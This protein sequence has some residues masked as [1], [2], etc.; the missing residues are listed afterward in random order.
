M[1]GPEESLRY[2]G[3]EL[4]RLRDTDEETL[5]RVVNE[6][7]AHLRPWM[8][9]VTPAG[10][11]PRAAIA[12]FLAHTRAAWDAGDSYSYAITVNG[13]IIG[14]CG[15][16]QRIGP[17]GLEVGYW[18]HPAYTGHGYATAAAAALVDQAFALSG[19]ERVQ[20]WHDIANTA[21]AAVPRRLGFTQIARRTPPRDP[22]TPGEV[23][24]DVV[25]ELLR[26]T[27]DVPAPSDRRRGG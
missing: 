20:I 3:V 10:E 1:S 19:I 21:S 22:M 7:L 25:W 4:R 5:H 8:S 17:D 13:Q 15:L 16:E 27:E 23:G 6:S 24:V 9:W 14:A 26:P 18:L 11:H 2:G 12:Q